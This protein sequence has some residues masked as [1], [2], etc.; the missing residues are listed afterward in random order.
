MVNILFTG[1]AGFIGSSIIAKLNKKK[2]NIYVV[3]NLLTGKYKNIPSGNRINF[4]KIDVNNKKNLLNQQIN[5]LFN[6]FSILLHVLVL[7]EH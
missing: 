7:K 5:Y 1:G 4:L 3:D 6:T 2:Y